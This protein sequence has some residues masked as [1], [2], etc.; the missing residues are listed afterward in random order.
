MNNLKTY[1]TSSNFRNIIFSMIDKIINLGI[2]EKKNFNYC[3]PSLAQA[4]I[5]PLKVSYIKKDKL[6]SLKKYAKVILPLSPTAEQ[7]NKYFNACSIEKFA[8]NIFNKDNITA[9]QLQ[10]FNEAVKEAKEAANA[11]LE[12]TLHVLDAEHIPEI[13]HLNHDK[14]KKHLAY[15]AKIKGSVKSFYI[16][17]KSDI[18]A[19]CMQGKPANYFDIYNDIN[20]DSNTLKMAILTQGNEIVARSLIWIDIPAADID[21]RK[22]QNPKHFYIDRIYTKTQ[23]H[24]AETQKQLYKDVI[25]YFN[26]EIDNNHFLPDGEEPTNKIYLPPCFN[27]YDIKNKIEAEQ[28]TTKQIFFSN[29]PR[30]DVELNEDAYNYYPYLDTYQYFN[31]YQQTLSNDQEHGSDILRLDSTSGDATNSLRECERCGHEHDEEESFYIETEAMSVC[32]DCA[33]YCEERGEHILTDEAVYNN[34]SGEYHY[35]G[36]LC[37]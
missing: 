35:R 16:G 14:E 5:N 2:K 21:R 9:E 26:I 10:E 22:K 33:T 12:K 32:E 15:E 11:K 7:R 6:K 17:E 29:S 24:R 1:K 28:N 31:T 25:K 19:S 18:N 4:I 30:F 20:T 3:A 27:C 13:Y 23:E 36:D 34:H 37:I 8:N